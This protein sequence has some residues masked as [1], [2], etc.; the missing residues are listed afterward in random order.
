[1]KRGG[2]AHGGGGKEGAKD[3]GGVWNPIFSKRKKKCILIK[4]DKPL[5]IIKIERN[6]YKGGEGGGGGWKKKS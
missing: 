4:I 3:L 5:I 2:G 6:E 1:L